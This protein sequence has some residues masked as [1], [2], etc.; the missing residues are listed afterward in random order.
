MHTV[1]TTYKVATEIF[2]GT[3][4]ELTRSEENMAKI[5]GSTLIPMAMKLVILYFFY[6]LS[7]CIIVLTILYSILHFEG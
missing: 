7:F 2:L 4:D 6:Y 1:P 5:R 3:I